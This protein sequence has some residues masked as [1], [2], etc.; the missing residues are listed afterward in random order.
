VPLSLLPP[1]ATATATWIL[2][3]LAGWTAL[4]ALVVAVPAAA[5]HADAAA[6]DEACGHPV[7][8]T[9]ERLA[10]LVRDVYGALGVERVAVVSYV[11]DAPGTGVIEACLG[12]PELVGARV[13]ASGG[14][15][16]GPGPES[17]FLVD[18]TEGWSVVS[19]PIGGP[20]GIAGIVAV[21][22]RRTR[23]LTPSDV[24]LLER[25]SRR[26]AL[27]AGERADRLSGRRTASAL[28]PA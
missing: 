15:G 10:W 14:F 16:W 9:S 19:V 27:V 18:G 1:V 13:R 23:G 22:T 26:A 2:V 17:S 4:A 11:P 6:L 24:E 8:A 12:R 20:A 3:V 28:W 7:V 21:A 5:K 25:L